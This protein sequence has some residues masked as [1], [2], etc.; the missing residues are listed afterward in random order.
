MKLKIEIL[1]TDVNALVQSLF[2]KKGELFTMLETATNN[3]FVSELLT[4][5]RA[6]ARV[7]LAIKE[8]VRK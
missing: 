5:I 1:E 4:D 6:I 7:E 8:G 3:D 2:E